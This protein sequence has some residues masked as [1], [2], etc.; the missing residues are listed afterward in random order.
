MVNK[1]T[2]NNFKSIAEYQLKRFQFDKYFYKNALDFYK[3]TFSINN[4]KILLGL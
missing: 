3:I 1:F 4:V 2:K